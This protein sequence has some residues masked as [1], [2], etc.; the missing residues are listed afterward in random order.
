[1]RGHCDCCMK[2]CAP[3][4]GARCVSQRCATCARTHPR[5]QNVESRRACVRV[6]M[7]AHL[8]LFELLVALFELREPFFALAR[9]R[10]SLRQLLLHHHQARFQIS[11][12]GLGPHLRRRPCRA[13]VDFQRPA[14]AGGLGGAD[15][16]IL[17]VPSGVFVEVPAAART[18]RSAVIRPGLICP[19]RAVS[20]ADA[21]AVRRL[22]PAVRARRRLGRRT[23]RR[24]P[25]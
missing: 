15:R 18:G 5:T 24:S 1:M 23:V 3:I 7:H 10:P 22:W 20:H 14:R 8:V 21:P 19:Q 16:R 12:R 13:V 17:A 2:V 4:S 25:L 11:D 9:H 6:R